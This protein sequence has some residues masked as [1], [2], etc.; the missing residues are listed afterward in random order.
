MMGGG[1]RIT[2]AMNSDLI[3]KGKSPDSVDL[4]G[5]H[6]SPTLSTTLFE[7]GRSAVCEVVLDTIKGLSFPS[8]TQTLARLQ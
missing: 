5:R 2:R 4:C 6:E 7:L 3:M 8:M 1:E